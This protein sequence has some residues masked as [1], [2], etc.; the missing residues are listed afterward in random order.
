MK[1]LLIPFL[2]MLALTNIQA[3]TANGSEENVDN[4]PVHEYNLTIDYE[5]VNFTGKDVK[6]MTIN[7][8]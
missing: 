8:K 7:G 1:K 2:A 3:Q 6:A 5:T 4:W